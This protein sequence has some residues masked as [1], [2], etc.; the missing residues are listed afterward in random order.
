MD[1]AT[2]LI[3]NL[4]P[5]SVVPIPV[6][7][8]DTD[9]IVNLSSAGVVKLSYVIDDFSI[10]TLG[11]CVSEYPKP[12]LTILIALTAPFD[13]VDVAVAVVPI[14]TPILEG[15]A[16]LTLGIELYPLP[17]EIVNPVI[18]PLLTVAV[19]DAP[20]GSDFPETILFYKEALSIPIFPSLKEIQQ[21][22]IV[23]KIEEAMSL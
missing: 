23:K 5:A 15:A 17:P 19:A 1:I 3:A 12:A 11:G 6:I 13:I 4:L 22:F 14:P 21:D 20:T 18:L 9:W 8:P 10:I 7:F 16:I 2:N